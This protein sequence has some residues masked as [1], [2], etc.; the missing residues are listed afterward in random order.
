MSSEHHFLQNVFRLLAK[1][2]IPLFMEK[3]NKSI[4]FILPS[5]RTGGMERVAVDLINYFSENNKF[6][7]IYLILLTKDGNDFTIH[8]KV[9]V[10]KPV[11]SQKKNKFLFFLYSL[12]FVRNILK[13]KNPHVCI[14]IGDRFNSFFLLSASF[15]DIKKVITNRRNP[16]LSNGLIIDIVDQLLYKKSDLLLTQTHKAEKYLKLKF[17]KTTVKVIPN[18]VTLQRTLNLP[19]ENIILNVARF[20][21]SKNQSF[22]IDTFKSLNLAGWTLIMCGDGPTFSELSQQSSQSIVFLGNISDVN[23]L[24]KRASI[25]AFPSLTEGF[26]NALAESMSFGCACISYDCDFGP[27]DLIEDNINGF[28]VHTRDENTFLKKIQLLV[29]NKELRDLFGKNAISKIS[30]F[31]RTSVSEK[32]YHTLAD[33]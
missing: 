22:L 33:L 2:R 11:F 21:P 1:S 31:D 15:L 3:T 10:F 4:C 9:S 7:N 32:Y 16:R 28:L 14:N 12:Y 27:S 24:Y 30:A 29:E 18:P 17:P 19:K 8:K 6:E 23:Q 5:L 13:E 26:P 20:V 25:F